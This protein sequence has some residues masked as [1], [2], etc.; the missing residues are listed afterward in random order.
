MSESENTTVTKKAKV[1]TIDN[2]NIFSEGVL[3]S[4]RTR[5]WG[6]TGKLSD[7][8]YSLADETIDKKKVR[9]SIDLL[10]DTSLIES[11]RS[12]RGQAMR[13][14]AMNSIFSPDKGLHF[15]RKS[16]IE[17]VDGRLLEFQKLFYEIGNELISKVKELE[18]EFKTAHPK[19]YNPDK[20]PSEETLKATIK[21][22]YVFRMFTVPDKELGVISP[23]IY[24]REMEKV[25]ADVAEMKK[26][27]TAEVCK[28]IMKRISS[29]KEQCEEGAISQA[30][31]NG[32]QTFIDRF[33]KVWDGF[34]GDK[35]VQKMAEDIRLYLQDTDAD[36]LTY[37]DEFRQ[38]VA[39]KS[40]KIVQA[41]EVKGYSRALDL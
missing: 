11:M 34:I 36:M 15:I 32:F 33:E 41:L 4:F 37:D 5:L 6:A 26:A 16:R 27:A 21:F 14:I 7:D 25:K 29:L 38:M 17:Y 28:E 31:L 9:A 20:Y 10:Q 40:A 3:I 18:E 35:E 22:E 13:I 19:L 30:T 12:L 39:N 23:E 2:T 1:L 24:K 8:M